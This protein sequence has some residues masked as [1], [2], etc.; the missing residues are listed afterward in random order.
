MTNMPSCHAS[1]DMYKPCATRSNPRSQTYAPRHVREITALT[2]AD[3]FKKPFSLFNKESRISIFPISFTLYIHA[4][5]V[6]EKSVNIKRMIKP[7][8]ESKTQSG[9]TSSFQNW[10]NLNAGSYWRQTEMVQNWSVWKKPL[11]RKEIT[12][13][14]LCSS[15]KQT[16][17]RREAVKTLKPS[18]PRTAQS[19]SCLCCNQFGGRNIEIIAACTWF[20]STVNASESALLHPRLPP[21]WFLLLFQ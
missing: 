18:P 6:N 17:G 7:I 2:A 4:L 13:A 8:C 20:W 21:K 1:G 12:T 10:P 15:S 11:V 9:T 5:I 14:L 19:A 16:T 3:A